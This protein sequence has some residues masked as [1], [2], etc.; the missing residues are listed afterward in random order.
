VSLR[1]HYNPVHR[2]DTGNAEKKVPNQAALDL[3]VFSLKSPKIS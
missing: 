2:R 3:S 1:C